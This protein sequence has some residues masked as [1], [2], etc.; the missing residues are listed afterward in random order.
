MEIYSSKKDVRLALDYGVVVG[1]HDDLELHGAL[2]VH[3]AS[4]LCVGMTPFCKL[5]NVLT[6]LRMIVYSNKKCFAYV[7]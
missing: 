1:M 3:G 2:G 4:G 7:K 5:Q 6:R